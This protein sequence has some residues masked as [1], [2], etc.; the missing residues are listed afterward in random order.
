MAQSLDA[1]L[2]FIEEWK[3]QASDVEVALFPSFVHLSKVADLVKSGGISVK[4]GAQDCSTEKVGAFTGEVSAAMLKE[5]GMTHCLVGHSERRKRGGET[6]ESLRAKMD[7]VL[8]ADLVPV[9]CLG[10]TEQERSEGRWK[11][12]LEIQSQVVK[13]ISKKFLVAYEP[14]WAIGTG[15]TASSQDIEE[16][17]RTL[18]GLV[19]PKTPI[20]YGGSVNASNASNIL[21][22]PEVSGLLV[23]GAS[24]K[25]PDFTQIASS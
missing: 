17:H 5:L 14:V 25:V 4:I 23:G 1:A 16:A 19:G 22:L 9:F 21:K 20:L 13:G 10:E 18:R 11:S 24:L 6:A 2:R 3:F 8:E 15:K 12:V 7:R